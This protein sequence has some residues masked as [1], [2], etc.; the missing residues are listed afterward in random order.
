MLCLYAVSG[1][2]GGE[3]VHVHDSRAG[4]NIDRSEVGRHAFPVCHR[5]SAAT[6]RVLNDPELKRR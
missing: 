5:G 1:S 3:G 2:H 4:I 6:V